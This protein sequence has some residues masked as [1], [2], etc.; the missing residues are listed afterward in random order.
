LKWEN[1]EKYTLIQKTAQVMGVEW[2]VTGSH[3]FETPI[4]RHGIGGTCRIL[5]VVN[6]PARSLS[7]RLSLPF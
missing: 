3:N 2:I 5:S 7:R 1:A 4:K 6:A